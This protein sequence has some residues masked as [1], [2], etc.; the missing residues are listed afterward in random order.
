MVR[1]KSGD[2]TGAL[3]ALASSEKINPRFTMTFVYR[4]NVHLARREW[5]PAIASFQQALAIEPNDTSAQQGLTRAK[6]SKA[7]A[8]RK[9]AK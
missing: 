1:A 2:Y 3:E 6:N 7:A 9:A 4:G 5:D 8:E